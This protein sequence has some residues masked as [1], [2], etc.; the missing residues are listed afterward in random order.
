MTIW[1]ITR[2]P[3]ALNWANQQQL[4]YDQ[5]CN[6][7]AITQIRAGDLIYGTLP[8]PLI[9]AANKRGAR[10]FHLEMNLP[11]TQRGTEL[12]AEQLEQLKAHWVEYRATQINP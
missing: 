2:H 10:Y 4:P 11:E 5:H 9:A 8:I 12:T 1:L 7:L 3:G 6:H